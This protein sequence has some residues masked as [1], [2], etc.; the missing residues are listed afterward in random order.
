[1]IKLLRR[2]FKSSDTTYEKV[3]NIIQDV[4]PTERRN[5]IKI[6]FVDDENYPIV[7]LLSNRGYRIFYK[8]DISYIIEVEPFDIV[9]LDI[10]GVWKSSEDSRQGFAAALEIKKLYP[11]KKV[12][13]Y[14]GSNVSNI[15]EDIKLIDDF[16]QKDSDIKKWTEKLD[17]HID[18]YFS[19]DYHWDK[20]YQKLANNMPADEINEI[21]KLYYDSLKSARF[22]TLNVQLMK[23][24]NNSSKVL[25]ITYNIVKLLNII[26]K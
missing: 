1:M 13:C 10:V 21:K 17:R 9:I 19:C 25:T 20:L 18:E 7:Q 14:S 4:D 8:K 22:D 24:F 12:I 5:R 15:A 6:L 2:F 3:F 23:I 16:I 26:V 11:E